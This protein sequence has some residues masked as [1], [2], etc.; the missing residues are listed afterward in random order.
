VGPPLVPAASGPPA[1]TGPSAIIGSF[2]GSI[3]GGSPR[4]SSTRFGGTDLAAV[5]IG[6]SLN[7]SALA[8]QR[9]KLEGL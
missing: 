6:F 9:Q 5:A 7:G 4:N 1:I 2:P 8:H 3:W